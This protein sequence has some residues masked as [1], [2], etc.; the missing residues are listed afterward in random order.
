M[1]I[2]V[3]VLGESGITGK[4][5][6]DTLNRLAGYTHVS[7]VANAD[8]VVASPGISPSDFPETA[9]PIVSEIEFAY[10]LFRRP[11]SA[12]CPKLIGITGTNGKTTVTEM[13][14]AVTRAPACGNIGTPLIT[15][16][17]HPDRPEW[18]AVELSSYQ[19]ETCHEFRPEIAVL[20]NITPDHLQRHGTMQEYARQK[21]KVFT[22][23][24]AEDCLIYLETDPE[25]QSVISLCPSRR[26]PLSEHSAEYTDIRTRL[27]LPG[28]HNIINALATV[29][30]AREAGIPVTRSLEILSQFRLADHRLEHVATL[31]GVT[32]IN[33]SKSTNPDA[34]M[35]AVRAYP[36]AHVLICGKDKELDL[37]PL[38][39]F[40]SESAKSVIVFGEIADRYVAVARGLG[41]P[42]SISQVA[43]LNSAVALARSNAEPGDVVLLSP[44]C[45]SF[46]Q[47]QNYEDRGNQ[48]KTV[49]TQVAHSRP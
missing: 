33:D 27:D 35:V 21:A 11:E 19:L 31:N 9:A 3:A 14:S 5:V 38:I 42:T 15:Y 12:Y 32:F 46:D 43:D 2:R 22:A 13:I 30:A 26:L 16:V 18:L 41:L 25:I 17:D 10:L 23:Q 47:F 36:N 45:S 24:T 40:L 7:T 1:T 37:V 6:I 48:Y 29:Y 4:A 8:W 44:A 20:L 34:T 39:R 28:A 49:V